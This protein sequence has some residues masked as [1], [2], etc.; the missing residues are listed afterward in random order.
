MERE[1]FRFRH[2]SPERSYRYI[3]PETVDLELVAYFFDYEFE[4]GLPDSAYAD[5]YGAADEWL[6]AWQDGSPPVLKYWSAPHFV[7]I[8]DERRRGRGG[9]YTLE[10]TLADL[11]LACVNRPT[12]A[13][14]V[15]AS[16]GLDLPA[17]GIQEIFEEFQRLGLMFLDEQFVLALAVPAVAGR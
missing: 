9:S 3:Y 6:S 2:R 4:G 12:T 8:Y 10:D 15:R 11:Y 16:L 14:A 1:T 13:A 5:I 7:Q 17:E